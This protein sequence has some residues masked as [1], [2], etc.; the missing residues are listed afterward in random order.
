M[1]NLVGIGLLGEEKLFN[2]Y[3]LLATSL[4]ISESIS[5]DI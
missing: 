2:I 1:A 5:V 4:I 3:L